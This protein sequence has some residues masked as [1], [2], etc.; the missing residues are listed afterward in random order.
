MPVNTVTFAAK[1]NLNPLP[2]DD[3]QIW[4]HTDANE[5]RLF[6]ID[7]ASII[8]ANEAK[9]AGIEAGAT[10]DQT[11]PEIKALYEAEANTNA[12]TDAEQAKLAGVEAGATAD[13]SAG[14][15]KTAY[16]SNPD[17]NAFSDAE[18]AKLAG[19]E[20][21][22]TADQTG[23]EI[24]ILYEAE[25]DTNAFSDADKSK[26]DS[27]TDTGSGQVISAAERTQISQ[28][29]T[30]IAVTSVAGQATEINLLRGGESHGET[31]PHTVESYTL[32]TTV[33][34]GTAV[35]RHRHTVVPSFAGGA[36]KTGNFAT[37][38]NNDGV[39]D[40]YIFLF[41][42]GTITLYWVG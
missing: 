12:F 28:N 29:Q 18:Q 17:T 33:N 16:E 21:G 30:D 1:A 36:D 42:F 20:A 34:W 35:I 2:G 11:G 41:Q 24:K 31:T 15:I 10:A 25:A 5:L 32:G 3:T 6:S 14:E 13:Q 23:A 19:V 22:A 37:E 7:A 26:L 8:N 39:T 38:Y 27:I 4:R 40:N 9:L